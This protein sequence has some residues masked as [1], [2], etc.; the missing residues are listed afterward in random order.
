MPNSQRKKS[1]LILTTLL[2]LSTLAFSASTNAEG[3]TGRTSGNEDITVALTSG[4]KHIERDSSFT[5]SILATNLDMNSEYTLELSFCDPQY[6]SNW[7]PTTQTYEYTHYCYDIIDDRVDTSVGIDFTPTLSTDSITITIDDPGLEQSYYDSVTNEEVESGLRNSTYVLYAELTIQG[8][9]VT[10]NSSNA[11]VL[12]G[13]TEEWSING[14]SNVLIGSN[15]NIFGRV[16]ITS[17]DQ[18]VDHYQVDCGIYAQGSSVAATTASSTQWIDY[19][20]GH[21]FEVSI[22]SPTTA[23]T[24][25]VMCDLIRNSDSSSMGTMTSENIEVIDETSNQDDATM[26]VS[27]AM[28]ATEGWGTVTI[29]AVDLDAGQE[30]R[31]DW[32][33]VDNTASTTTI[34]MD[35][36]HIWVAGNDGTHTYDLSFHDL[37]DTTD[38]CITVVFKA[39]TTELATDSSVCWI[40]ASTADADGDGVYD[41]ND[42]CEN[43]PVGA[44]VQSDGCSDSDGDGVDSTLETQCGSDPNDINSVPT[45]LDNDG[46]CDLLDTDADGD[47]ALNV[48]EIAAGTDPMDA[49]SFPAN[50][51]PTCAV[52]YSLEVDG[53]P[54]SFEGDAAIPALSGATAQAGVDSLTP[55]VITIPNGSY[56]ITAHCIDTDGDDITVTVNDITV[57][58]MAGEVSAGAII[59]IGE[60]VDETVDVTISWTD[61]TDTLTAI[62]TVN[63]DGDASP[64]SVPGFGFMLGMMSIMLAGFVALR[65]KE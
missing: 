35:N 40:S 1:A 58:P 39:G 24:H 7:N 4:T 37:A 65:R 18:F 43:T 55:P 26:A 17:T 16:D 48:D 28:H 2:V 10:T 31:F 52:Y 47:G 62:I 45:D 50:M 63:M 14:L 33:V 34:M 57:G 46:T 60:D 54:T 23:G 12:G 61:G 21:S 29:S 25:F 27:V 42:L 53:M 51:L 11:F 36:D 56:Y 22:P 20:G 5:L 59:V 8:A 15:L 64:A 49:N 6:E 30:Y 9:P 32:A 41:K 3:T 38:A 13:E 44:T 19:W